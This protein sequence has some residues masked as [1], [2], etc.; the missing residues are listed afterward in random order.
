MRW[1]IALL[2]F[3]L[4]AP[5]YGQKK[6][7]TLVTVPL[8]GINFGGQLPFGDLGQRFGPNLKVGGAFLIKNKKNWIYGLEAFYM[9]GRN[10]KEDVLKQ[11]KN[12]EGYVTDNEGYPADIR[13][14]QRGLGVHA[15]F[16]KVLNFDKDLPNSGIMVT[17]GAGFLQ[18]KIHLYDAQTKIAAIKGDLRQGYDRF[19][20]GLSLSQFI[21]YLHISENRFLNFYA[22]F[23]AYQTF[24]RSF[25]KQN[26]DTGLP[27][28][29]RRFDGLFGAR[30][31]WIL[32]LYKRTP[33]DYY[34]Y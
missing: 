6:I 21:G 22:G 1:T 13:V 2:A 25:R 3:C 12:T 27:D 20:G 7:D 34:Y 24:A 14:T 17:V 28:T 4:A 19:S 30:I 31:G 18:H 5:L 23:E 9:F 15:H 11:L 32:P 33:D 10:V 26:Y 29:G 16:G 8:V